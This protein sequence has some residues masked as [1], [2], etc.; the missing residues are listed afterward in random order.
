M[1]YLD[2]II[3]VIIILSSAEGAVQGFIYEICSL[4]GLIA[5]FFLAIEYAEP[6]AGYLD[7]IPLTGW[8][9]RIIAF[10]FIL[11]AVNMIFR[12]VGKSLRVILRKVFMGWFDRFL[13]ALFGLV[14]GIAFVIFVLVILLLTPISTV[15]NEEA[16]QTKL[17]APAIEMAR[18]FID[19]LVSS[20]KTPS[21]VI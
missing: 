7:F 4:S 9:L 20:D 10:M 8:I 6:A 12:L 3:L 5:G 18:P 21:E 2:I 17:M 15:L 19:I 16:P 14:R 11:I 1:H 13:G